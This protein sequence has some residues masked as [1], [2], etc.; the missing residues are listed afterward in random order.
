MILETGTSDLRHI[1]IEVSEIVVYRDRVVILVITL[2]LS[3]IASQANGLDEDW[4]KVD[5]NQTI[6]RLKAFLSKYYAIT[7][8][9]QAKSA[10]DQFRKSSYSVRTD[11]KGET[12]NLYAKGFSFRFLKDSGSLI[13]IDRDGSGD[14]NGVKAPKHS[15]DRID[16][17]IRRLL[18]ILFPGMSVGTIICDNRWYWKTASVCDFGANMKLGEVDVGE[19]VQTNWRRDRMTLEYLS[20]FRPVN[21]EL[22]LKQKQLSREECL[23]AAVAHMVQKRPFYQCCL[24]YEQLTVGRL[25]GWTL[26]ESGKELELVDYRP[27]SPVRLHYRFFFS[28]MDRA[29][30]ATAAAKMTFNVGVHNYIV[31]VDA[32][33]GK[34][35][36]SI[37]DSGFFVEQDIHKTLIDPV[38]LPRMKHVWLLGVAGYGSM[39]HTSDCTDN[40]PSGKRIYAFSQ[41]YLLEGVYTPNLDIWFYEDKVWKRFLPD[42][43]M[44]SLAEKAPN[45]DET[46]VAKP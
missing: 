46:T 38:L 15:F 28:E 31:S 6:G 14:M 18:P 1:N 45:L 10:L 23:R 43:R 2:L 20:C 29:Y 41:N 12:L 30:A 11:D 13:H 3:V 34:V 25:R 27:N 42:K 40:R 16:G 35:V 19:P 33:T 26:G 7:G 22:L 32:A 9:P 36:A 5:R 37:Y 4:G 24:Y 17:A 21:Y 39:R 8:D 44:K